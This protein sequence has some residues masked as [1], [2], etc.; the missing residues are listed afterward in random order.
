MVD[1][2]VRALDR[3]SFS[4]C[5]ILWRSGHAAESQYVAR[6]V[7]LTFV[8][9]TPPTPRSRVQTALRSPLSLMYRS[10]LDLTAIYNLSRFA[11]ELRRRG[12][13]RSSDEVVAAMSAAWRGAPAETITFIARSLARLSPTGSR[14]VVSPA[15]LEEVWL[16]AGR[17][18]RHPAHQ[19]FLA[20]SLRYMA[21][22]LRSPDALLSFINESLPYNTDPPQGAILQPAKQS[23]RDAQHLTL[24]LALNYA[25]HGRLD[26]ATRLGILALSL[27]DAER[28]PKVQRVYPSL[29]G[30]IALRH[31]A[32]DQKRAIAPPWGHS[33]RT[34]S[35]T[36]R[37]LS[38][39]NLPSSAAELMELGIDRGLRSPDRAT[40]D[41]LWNA[42]RD[43][44]MAGTTLK[45]TDRAKPLRSSSFSVRT[46]RRLPFEMGWHAATEQDSVQ[47]EAHRRGD[48][49]AS[50][51]GR[52]PLA[53]WIETDRKGLRIG[54]Q[55]TSKL[56]DFALPKPGE[57]ER[58]RRL[59]VLIESRRLRIMP[60]FRSIDLSIEHETNPVYFSIGNA[61]D[62][63][64]S[65]FAISIVHGKNY[66]LLHATRYHLP[67]IPW[68]DLGNE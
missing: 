68:P 1:S 41:V 24:D 34:L 15:T 8:P 47:T 46:T 65:D 56:I 14:G 11:N 44:A 12:D 55:V 54:L 16:Y 5:R 58:D 9:P 17:D 42:V 23:N 10:D 35:A 33:M 59:I 19:V 4:T 37:A 13:Y 27:A 51:D 30:E 52:Q 57:D 39:R 64:N 62:V 40:Q 31:I 32:D 25:S 43:A 38:T 45:A 6:A 28:S 63:A 61:V 3:A 21:E 60:S 53:V 48:D 49:P 67:T 50:V 29:L 20:T 26:S 2:S 7:G 22:N 66:T 18:V 36:Y